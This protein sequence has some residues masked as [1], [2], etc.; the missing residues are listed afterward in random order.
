MKSEWWRNCAL[1]AD[2]EIDAIDALEAA[3]APLDPELAKV[4]G[5]ISALE[6]CHH[7]AE[8]WIAN[9]IEAIGSGTTD[10]GLGTRAPESSHPGEEVWRNACAALAAW[11]AGSP[12]ASVRLMIGPLPAAELLS[13]LGE[14]SPLKE[15]QVQRLYEKIRS[16]IGWPRPAGEPYVWLLLDADEHECGYREACPPYY[17]EHREFW[18]QTARALIRDRDRGERA[19]LSLALAIDMLW[20]CHWRFV[21][22][23]RIV[24][25]A[26]GGDLHPQEPF[27]ACGRNI[28][29]LANRPWMEQVSR[30]LR[31]F[32]D[33]L[34]PDAEVDR[35]LLK[36]LGEPSDDKRW[37]ALSLDKTIRLQLDPPTDLRSI[38]SLAGPDWIRSAAD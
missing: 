35:R 9:I 29:L 34:E 33:A 20:P 10:K 30:T 14:R 36:L 25:R 21:H 37:L 23:L 12:A 22:N 32:C 3:L 28:Q 4:R 26:I 1:S 11:N 17:Q 7:K 18:Q 13:C 38:S 31:V 8:R 27:A 16:S 6:L 19:E 15:W 5:L 2:E 24:L